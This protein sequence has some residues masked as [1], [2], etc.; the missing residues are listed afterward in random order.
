M[1][2]PAIRHLSSTSF[3]TLIR[4]AQSCVCVFDCCFFRV[5]KQLE[6]TVYFIVN[7]QFWISVFLGPTT[8]FGS[9][10][11]CQYIAFD[12]TALYRTLNS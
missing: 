5:H 12:Q 10:I 6:Q 2:C 4:T 8:G 11:F 9:N 3:L 1:I 7:S